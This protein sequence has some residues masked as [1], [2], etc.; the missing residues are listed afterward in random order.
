MNKPF[1][2]LL[3]AGLLL[4]GVYAAIAW[5]LWYAAAVVIRGY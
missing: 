5:A 4:L 3:A 2:E 1:S